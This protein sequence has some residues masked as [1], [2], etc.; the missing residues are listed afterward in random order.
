MGREVVERTVKFD[1]AEEDT[2][3]TELGLV[4]WEKEL[5]RAAQQNS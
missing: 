1:K 3:N 4:Y 5:G 2:R